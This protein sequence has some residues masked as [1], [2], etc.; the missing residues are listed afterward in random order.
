MKIFTYS[1]PRSEF[2]VLRKCQFTF[3]RLHFTLPLLAVSQLLSTNNTK[4]KKKTRQ[5]ISCLGLFPYP[6]IPFSTWQENK[7]TLL[8]LPLLIVLEAMLAQ[9]PFVHHLLFPI[10]PKFLITIASFRYLVL[11][12][13]QLYVYS[14]LYCYSW[15]SAFQ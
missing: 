13:L 14:T 1:Q 7:L 15:S 11:Q 10:N 8:K 9:G 3:D 2:N 4:R 5:P 12:I 6:I